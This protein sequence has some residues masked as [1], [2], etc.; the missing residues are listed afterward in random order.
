MSTKLPFAYWT[1]SS[2]R[3]FHA[4]S[5]SLKSWSQP[6]LWISCLHCAIS[7]SLQQSQLNSN[8]TGKHWYCLSISSYDFSE[9][10][11]R[12]QACN[13]KGVSFNKKTFGYAR[14][15]PVEL[16]TWHVFSDKHYLQIRQTFELPEG[17]LTAATT[18]ELLCALS[19]V[20]RDA[21][22]AKALGCP[23]EPG[24]MTPI[25][26]STLLYQ[27]VRQLEG[28]QAQRAM[29]AARRALEL[30]P[31]DRYLGDHSNFW[32]FNSSALSQ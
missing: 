2:K 20:I 31:E 3:N 18:R 23:P 19:G 4:S 8:H 15:P 30:C 28:Y 12:Q 11:A 21:H 25:S 1:R 13:R 22:W 27:G 14:C 7:A 29:A 10:S 6:Y 24:L 9:H 16:S 5:A 32:R 17:A 26:I